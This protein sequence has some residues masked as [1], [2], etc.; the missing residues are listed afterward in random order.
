MEQENIFQNKVIAIGLTGGIAA[1]KICLLINKFRSFGAQIRLIATENSLNF[2]TKTTLQTIARTPVLTEQFDIKKYD[3]N[4]KS[5]QA[6]ADLFILAPASANTISKVAGGIADNLL[7]SIL[8]AWQKQ[9]LIAPAMN[10]GMWYNPATQNSIKTLQKRGAFIV[11]PQVAQTSNGQISKGPMAEIS[12]IFESAKNILSLEQKLKDKKVLVIGGNMRED[13]DNNSF[14]SVKNTFEKAQIIARAAYLNGAKV[15][16]IDNKICE[17]PYTQIQAHTCG[18]YKDAILKNLEN[19]DILIFA[20][21]L[22][23][24]QI[25]KEEK[26]SQKLILTLEP[27]QDFIK[28]VLPKNKIKASFLDIRAQ[29][30]DEQNPYKTAFE[31]LQSYH[32]KE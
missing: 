1:Y 3:V 2:I 22:P 15:I 25:E 16:L 24:W 13:F 6:E 14:I 12:D 9:L 20:A 28:E 29:V 26:T 30:F 8:C 27:S 4:H 5:L 17:M 23:S 19:T 7:T 31:I 10:G 21:T 11:G 18:E 32:T